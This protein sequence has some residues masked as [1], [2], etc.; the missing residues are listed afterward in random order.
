[1]KKSLFVASCLVIFVFFGG[2]SSVSAEEATEYLDLQSPSSLLRGAP[3]VKKQ[4]LRSGESMSIKVGG[5][6]S[7][8]IFSKYVVKFFVDSIDKESIYVAR[9]SDYAGVPQKY[10]EKI[11]YTNGMVTMFDSLIDD[12]IRGPA[13]GS[14]TFLVTNYSAESVSVKLGVSSGLH[15]RSNPCID[16]KEIDFDLNNF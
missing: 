7:N 13:S 16:F 14:E 5:M 11:Y 1:M 12:E 2:A 4:L 8:S 9:R 3:A 6:R 10:H 15:L